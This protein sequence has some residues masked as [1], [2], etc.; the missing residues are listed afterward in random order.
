MGKV[1]IDRS[2]WIL[3][4]IIIVLVATSIVLYFQLKPNY[5]N[6]DISAKRPIK[7][8]I[9]V[10]GDEGLSFC[11]FLCI[12]TTTSQSALFDLPVD[13]GCWDS[14]KSRY[15]F[16]SSLYT[17]PLKSSSN[18]N[19]KSVLSA[20]KYFSGEEIPYTIE[21]DENQLEN[22]I[23]LMGGVEVFLTDPISSVFKGQIRMLPAG[24]FKIQGYQALYY[25]K[26][27][28]PNESG[29]EFLKRR[30]SMVKTIL[31]GCFSFS[32]QIN[33]SKIKSAFLSCFK[34]NLDSSSIF[35]LLNFIKNE[36]IELMQLNQMRGEHKEVDGSLYFLPQKE[37]KIF[38]EQV[39][40][41]IQALG[42][43]SFIKRELL[44]I[45]LEILNGTSRT[46]LAA[47]TTE[48]YQSYGYN[49]IVTG[50]AD[51]AEYSKTLVIARNK[52]FLK[53]ATRI[54]GII[55]CHAVSVKESDPALL[56]DSWNG[57]DVTIILGA[58]YDYYSCH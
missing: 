35:T 54:A 27:Q 12:D 8:L 31:S 55:D 32:R 51:N 7:I 34:S 21:I 37:G 36:D 52:E 1:K 26:N 56:A 50:N 23:D 29:I 41:I 49:V 25:L 4:L 42:D 10:R 3:L 17:S 14:T 16:L 45:N 20:I 48:Y 22:L 33:S 40:Q 38:K 11:D 44:A 47:R 13:T 9:L 57:S 28:L 39:R 6:E 30:Q 15:A 2:L 53:A 43:E 58:D 5:I 46:M 18:E 19:C 24:S